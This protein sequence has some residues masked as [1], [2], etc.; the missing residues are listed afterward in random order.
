MLTRIESRIRGRLSYMR[1]VVSFRVYE[2]NSH[3]KTLLNS[4]LTSLYCCGNFRWYYGLLG[5]C[6]KQVVFFAGVFYIFYI[7]VYMLRT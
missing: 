2:K 1:Y 7:C 4:I 6:M 5:S 3:L